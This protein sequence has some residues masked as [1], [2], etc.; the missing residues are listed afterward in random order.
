MVPAAVKSAAHSVGVALD[1]YIV[2]TGCLGV[3]V[4]NAKGVSI[5]FPQDEISPLYTKNLDFA[6]KNS[7]TTFLKAFVS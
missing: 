2:K 1:S 5:Y 4:K 6:K 7:W 3:R